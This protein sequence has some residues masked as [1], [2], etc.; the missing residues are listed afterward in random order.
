MSLEVKE[1]LVYLKGHKGPHPEDYHQA[2]Y[3]RLQ[4][5]LGQCRT[6]AQ[7]RAFLVDALQSLAD[8]VCTN[9]SQLHRLLTKSRG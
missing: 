6:T 1:N 5:A 3:Q 7:C 2:I 8:E 4:R 9:G